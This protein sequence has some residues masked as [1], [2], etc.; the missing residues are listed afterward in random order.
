M[1]GIA[2]FLERDPSASASRVQLERMTS[3][4]AHRGPDDAGHFVRGN[5]ALGHRRLSIIDL[6]QAA[7]QPMSNDDGSLWIT[8]N[9]E[10]YNYR[11]LARELRSEGVR[12]R[13]D[14]DTEV[15]LRL[16]ER[17]GEAFLERLD[18]MF[19]IAIWDQ[20]RRLLLLAR[21][22]LGIKPLYY[23]ETAGRL[24]FA[25]ELKS[26]LA[27]P[28]IRTDLNIDALSDYLHLLSIPDPQSILSG[29]RK[30]L[31]GH[32]LRA[33]ADGISLHKYWD[34]TVAPDPRMSLEEAIAQFDLRFGESVVSHMVADVPVGAFLSG[35]VDSSAIVARAAPASAEAIRTF[36][37]TFPGM[38]E[39]DES[40]HA[41]S[42]ARRYGT[43]HHEFAVTPD[44]ISALP[45]I[46]WHADEPF[47]VSSGFALYFLAEVARRHVKVVLTGDGADEVFGGYVWRHAD[48]A[49]RSPGLH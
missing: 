17:H 4:I 41:A 24:S 32:Y 2:G 31:P 1:C 25:S 6:S 14:S 15:L 45:K 44:L 10:C 21:D 30:L 39:F 3:L 22:R 9:G 27:D 19:A 48:F 47:A 12:L 49:A 28:G 26:L 18:G 46:A 34:V 35:G 11:D 8:Y 16:Y 40:V 37:V 5:V 43:N 23:S 36:S 20:R 42:V 13:S 7:H 29:V 33:S 38:G